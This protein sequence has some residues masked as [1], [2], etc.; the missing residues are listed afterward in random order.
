MPVLMSSASPPQAAKNP[1]TAYANTRVGPTFT[2]RRNAA[3]LS[4]PTAYRARPKRPS[5]IGTHT[6][7]ST[8]ISRRIPWVPNGILLLIAVVAAVWVPIRLGRLGLALY[9][10]GS[11]RTAAGR[12]RG[13]VG[14]RSLSA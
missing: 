14:A 10:V 5:R 2:P 13:V 9:A 3:V 11:D 4:L 12:R 7:A 6:T 1:P 8:A